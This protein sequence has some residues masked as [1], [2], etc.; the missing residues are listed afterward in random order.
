MVQK[1][2]F[3]EDLYYRLKVVELRLPPLRERRGDIQLLA[4]YFLDELNREIGK[5][6]EGLSEDAVRT[7]VEYPW[8]GNVR[9][10]K[11][12]IEHA[13]ILCKGSIIGMGDLPL[14]IREHRPA[15]DTFSEL[16]PRDEASIILETLQNARWNKTEAARALGMSRQTLYRKLK[17]LGAEDEAP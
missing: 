9:E 4:C 5:R 1:G 11:H 17:N 6:I 16:I 10:L 13:S 12:A 7:L 2:A 3:R 15:A 8:P 14:E